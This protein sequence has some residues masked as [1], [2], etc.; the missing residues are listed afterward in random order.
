MA[1]C[2]DAATANCLYAS[3]CALKGVLGQATGAF[4]DVLDGVTL[5][6]MLITETKKIKAKANLPKSVVM[7][8]KPA[9]KKA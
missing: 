1:S 5:E 7:Q 8:F 2:F 3:A 4:L 9:R 6:Q